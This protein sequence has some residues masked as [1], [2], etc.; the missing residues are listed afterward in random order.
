LLCALIF[1][2][3]KCRI[4][5]RKGI[6]IF[7]KVLGTTMPRSFFSYFAAGDPRSQWALYYQSSVLRQS[8]SK[9]N[10]ATLCNA[11]TSHF[12]LT[13]PDVPFNGF[14]ED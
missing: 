10:F 9:N 8:F 5:L 11:G 7:V 2:G 14:L 4:L 13:E 1:G 6:Y 3:S 12:K